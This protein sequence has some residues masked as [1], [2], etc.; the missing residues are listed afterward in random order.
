MSVRVG[1]VDDEPAVMVDMAEGA[2]YREN[3]LEAVK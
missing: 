1:V 3:G 2:I